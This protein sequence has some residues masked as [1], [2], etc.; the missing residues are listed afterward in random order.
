MS[1]AVRHFVIR[2]GMLSR[3]ND[4]PIFQI[5]VKKSTIRQKAK[6]WPRKGASLAC[7]EGRKRKEAEYSRDRGQERRAPWLSLVEDAQRNR[8]AKASSIS[9]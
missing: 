6:G 3:P 9:L 8:G 5:R 1:Y 2:V 4:L 7:I